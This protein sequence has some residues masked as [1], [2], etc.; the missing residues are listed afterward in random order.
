MIDR[1]DFEKRIA[2]ALRHGARRYVPPNPPR[3]FAAEARNIAEQ[4][5]SLFTDEVIEIAA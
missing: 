4:L 3:D 1:T 2:A 5:T